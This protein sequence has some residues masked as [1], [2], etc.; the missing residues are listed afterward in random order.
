VA[1]K[2]EWE[3]PKVWSYELNSTVVLYRNFGAP[4]ALAQVT[5]IN[6]KWTITEAGKNVNCIMKSKAAG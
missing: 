2:E 3:I 4:R 5:N 1:E 6:S